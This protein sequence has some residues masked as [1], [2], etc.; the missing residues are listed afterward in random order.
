MKLFRFDQKIGKFRVLVQTRDIAPGAIKGRHVADGAV[1]GDKIGT[2]TVEGR[3]I[4]PEAVTGEKIMDNTVTGKNIASGA[5]DGNHIAEESITGDEIRP[6]GVKPGKIADGAVQE[7]NI[8]DGNVTLKKLSGKLQTFL[9][10]LAGKD[11]DLQNQIDS[12]TISGMAVSNNF[13]DDPHIGVSQKTLTD[14]FNKVWAKIEEITGE[15]LLGFQMAVTPEYYVGEDGCS[16]HV[17]ATTV[18]TNGVFEHIAFYVD[19]GLVFEADDV[20]DA[21][22][23]TEISETALVKCVAKIMGIEYER[24]KVI[25]HYSSFWLGAG[26]SYMEVMNKAN[27]I[28]ITNGMRGAYDINVN[29]GNKIIIV[30]GESLAEGFIRADLNSVEIPFTESVETVDGVRYKVFTSEN[31]YHA[32][33]YNIDING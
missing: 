4:A 33:T 15:S 8:K 31:A 11:D 19:G 17:K 27:L 26:N 6:N 7:R 25:T 30:V 10:L 23:D 28:P 29:E 20:E 2:E 12:L 21:E 13:G 9:K 1:T 5:I 24:E 32:G 16:V 22:F 18:N 3:N 14:A